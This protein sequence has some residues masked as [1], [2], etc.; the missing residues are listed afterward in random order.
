MEKLTAAVKERKSGLI[1]ANLVDFD[2]L[3]G[4]RKDVEGFAKSLEEF[5][6]ALSDFLPLLSLSDLLMITADHGCDPDPRW[7]TTDHSREYVP[8][9]VYSPGIGAGA[10]LG[11]R[12]TLADMGQT[13]AENFGTAIPHGN[14]F[15]REI[16]V[17]FAGAAR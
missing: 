11:V 2:M 10:D 3:Y 16:S 17:Q 5:D 9:V 4:H 1:F 13:V 8:I 12:D 6:R 14:S 15:L 7:A